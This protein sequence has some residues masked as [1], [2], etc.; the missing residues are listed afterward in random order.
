MQLFL[1]ETLQQGKRLNVAK[2]C[3][4]AG[5][6]NSEYLKGGEFCGEEQLTWALDPYSS[7]SPP[8]STR[9]V[10]ALSGRRLSL[11]ANDLKFVATQF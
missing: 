10:K 2:N 4:R 11:P 9:T 5:F 8:I 6:F 7:S 3:G 1:P